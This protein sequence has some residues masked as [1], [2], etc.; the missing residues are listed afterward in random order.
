[1]IAC[2]ESFAEENNLKFSTDPNPAK[3]KTK[4]IYMC[5]KLNNVQYPAPLKL[6]G[7]NLPWVTHAVHLGHELHQAG[8][9][10]HDARIKRAIFIE[11]STDIREMFSFAH[12]AQILQAVRVYAAHFYGSMLWDL[13]G[14]AA[15]Q[16]FR[17]WNTCVKLAW[18]VPRWTHNYYVE[19]VLSAGIPHVRQQIIC[20]YLGFFKNLRS[21]ASPEIQL[22][23]NMVGRDAGSVLGSNLL[24]IEE[25]FGLDPWGT[26]SVKLGQ[27]YKYYAVPEVDEWRL[28]L[29]VKLLD[30]RREMSVCEERSV[31]VSELIDSLCHS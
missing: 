3:S 28:P 26:S 5:G 17:S 31:A 23:V 12:P 18:G 19:H 15:N 27:V 20:Q 16:V 22:L 7:V 2:C 30:Q 10:E 9:M 25:E 4:C 1:M 21:S 13:Y 8:T 11:K 6:Y 14:K 29:L 24:R